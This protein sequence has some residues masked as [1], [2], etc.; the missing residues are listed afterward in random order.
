VSALECRSSSGWGRVA[1]PGGEES[2]NC[3]FCRESGKQYPSAGTRLIFAL[4]RPFLRVCRTHEREARKIWREC[5]G[6]DP[7]Q[8]LRN[9]GPQF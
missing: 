7:A 8:R 1:M 3:D 9:G 4:G 2:P 5:G 6:S